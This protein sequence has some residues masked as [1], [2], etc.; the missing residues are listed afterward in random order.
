[1]NKNAVLYYFYSKKQFSTKTKLAI[2]RVNDIS[3]EI[4]I[5]LAYRVVPESLYN[6]QNFCPKVR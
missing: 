5:N 3:S 1:M 2:Y 6:L 4:K